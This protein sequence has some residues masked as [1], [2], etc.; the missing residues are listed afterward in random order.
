[1][2]TTARL[3]SVF[4]YLVFLGIFYLLEKKTG[5]PFVSNDKYFLIISC[6][7]IVISIIACVYEHL[8]D[9]VYEQDHG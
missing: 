3:F 8:K 5:F 7:W 1:M 2:I 9:K 6:I 4:G